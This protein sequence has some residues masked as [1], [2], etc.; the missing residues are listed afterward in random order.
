VRRASPCIKTVGS[1]SS[2]CVEGRFCEL[3]PNGFL[4]SSRAIRYSRNHELHLIGH[5]GAKP[6]GYA[7]PHVGSLYRVRPRPLV[8]GAPP[9][10]LPLRRTLRRRAKRHLLGACP[11]LSGVRRGPFPAGPGAPRVHLP[12]PDAA[13]WGSPEPS[14]RLGCVFH[15]TSARSCA[16]NFAL[17]APT[18][19]VAGSPRVQW[20]RGIPD[21]G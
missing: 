3:L 19:R 10:S 8:G 11:C 21:K 13:P 20:A 2:E 7:C 17:M 9:R 16:A 18:K 15:R 6:P 12:A 4:G 1:Y 14:L 5:D